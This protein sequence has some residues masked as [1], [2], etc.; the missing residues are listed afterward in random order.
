MTT[1]R[2]VSFVGC[3]LL[4]IA[5]ACGATFTES[6][7][8]EGVRILAVRA[9]PPYATPGTPVQLTALAYDARSSKPEPM[10]LSW[11]PSVCS[12]P[13]NDD[14]FQCYPAFIPEYPSGV[15]LTSQL[16]PGS[17]FSFTMPADVIS[18][19]AT[20]A[21]TDPYGLATA[22]LMA[23]AGHVQATPSAAGENLNANPFGCFDSSDNALGADEYVFAYSVVYSFDDRTNTNPTIDHLTFGGNAIDLG[24]GIDVAVC[25]Q[26]D[27]EK[28]PTT[29]LDTVVTADNQELDPS[30]L[31]IS[32]HPLKEQLYV[33]YYVTAGKVKSDVIILYDPTSG[34]LDDTGDDFYSPRAVGDYLLWAV[35][36]DN[37]GGVSWVQS[38]IHVH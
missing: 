24:A 12:D 35:L 29:K 32:G 19:H 7:Q 5:S 23:C 9:D 34:K 33:D 2:R 17:T 13:K 21:G 11:L 28:C 6:N 20:T 36:H 18:A 15:D 38:S 31:D 22:F 8:V 1:P 30:A 10:V 26:S 37:R 16:T 25:S 3:M 4:T 14:Y 27:L